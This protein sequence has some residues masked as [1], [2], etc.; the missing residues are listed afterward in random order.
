MK[1]PH[2]FDVAEQDFDEK[3]LKK[4]SEVPVVVDFWAPWCGPCR[5]LGPL[6]EKMID[7]RKGEVLLAKVNIDDE[8]NL[9]YK[10]NVQSIPL[11]IGFRDGKGVSEFMGLVSEKQMADFLDRL[12]PTEA[13]RLIKQALDLETSNPVEA[14]RIYR[15]AIQDEPEQELA[16]LGLTRILLAQKND[17]EAAERLERFIA[18]GDNVDECERLRAILW[19]RRQA[20]DSGDESTL[21]HQVEIDAKN[22][23]ARFDLGCVRAA[24]GDYQAGLQL[25]LE[26]GELD[27]KLASGKVKEAMVKIFHALG[28]RHALSDEYRDKLTAILY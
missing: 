27:R 16:I 20:N 26:A 23:N 7:E 13:E 17:S 10:Y 22:A 9:A 8:Q 25:L 14:E 6:L 3:V 1:S 18:T 28:V 4:S 24:D 11:V 15:Q 21:R 2:V 19:L 12:S 5:S